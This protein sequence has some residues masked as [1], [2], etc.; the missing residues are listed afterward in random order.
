LRSAFAS[1]SGKQAG[2]VLTY[3]HAPG[4][5]E[6]QQLA[7]VVNKRLQEA[8]SDVFTK[9]TIYDDFDW[10]DRS[11]AAYGSVEFEIFFLSSQCRGS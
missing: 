1:V 7:A 8:R 5:G 9:D 3:V 10:K 4:D 6:G 11:R 2:L